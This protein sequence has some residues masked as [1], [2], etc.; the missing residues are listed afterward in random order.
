MTYQLTLSPNAKEDLDIFIKS[1]NKGLLKKIFS[2]FEELKEHPYSGT[3]K[4]EPLKYELS[5]KWSR[6]ITSEHRMVY[7]VRESMNDI[8]VLSLR[9]H[10][11]QK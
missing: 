2:L 10:Y 8:Y 7:I 4:P 6:R 9:Y 11:P 1:G 3:G 5:G